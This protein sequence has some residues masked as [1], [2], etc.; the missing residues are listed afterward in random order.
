MLIGFLALYEIIGAKITFD[1]AS[2]CGLTCPPFAYGLAL[3][4]LGPMF[5]YGIAALT[6]W[7]G[8]W[9]ARALFIRLM[10]QVADLPGIAYQPV[11]VVPAA[12]S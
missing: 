7:F 10:C 2:A 4:V 11:R 5:I 3:L 12:K 6:S 8:Y 9:T 1:A